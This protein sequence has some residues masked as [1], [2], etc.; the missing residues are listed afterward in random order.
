MTPWVGSLGSWFLM[1]FLV[2]VG[3]SATLS[4][5]Q[6]IRMVVENSSGTSPF[7]LDP[8]R[9]KI[10]ENTIVLP[11]N[12]RQPHILPDYK[13]A[14]V[15]VDSY[16]TNTCGLIE[17]FNRQSFAKKMDACFSDPLSVDS[18]YL[19]L[20]YLTFA[21]GL[22]MAT[23]SPGSEEEATIKRLR[24]DQFDRAEAF[25]RSAKCLADPVSGFEDADFWSVQ[26]LSLMSVYMLAVSK[27]NA[28]YAYYGK[29][30]AFN[31]AEWL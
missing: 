11:P 17:I 18:A 31:L 5:L 10:M 13:T 30:R 19:C 14:K 26:A 2:Y 9:H 20:L 6:L 25:F 28:A 23:P 24:T 27:R 1:S 29:F 15:L 4:Y 7:T 16:F 3:D 8:S 12:I 22:V 21:I